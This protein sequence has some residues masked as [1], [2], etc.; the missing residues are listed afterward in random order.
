MGVHL[1]FPIVFV[2]A[3]SEFGIPRSTPSEW[4]GDVAV[5]VWRAGLGDLVLFVFVWEVG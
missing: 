2:G 1:G 4:G 5:G 3:S